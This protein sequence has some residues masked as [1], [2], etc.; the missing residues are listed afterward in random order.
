MNAKFLHQARKPDGSPDPATDDITGQPRSPS[1]S[2][3]CC[4]P[5]RPVVRVLMPPTASRPREVDLLLCGHHYRVSCEALAAA[6]ATV[7]ELPEMA[8]N[9]PVALLPDLPEHRVPVS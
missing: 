2:R 3:A 4:C 1:A 6:D 5:A 9:R 8:G 7:T